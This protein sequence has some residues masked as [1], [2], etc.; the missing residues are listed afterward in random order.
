MSDIDTLTIGEAREA[1][2]RGKEIEKILGSKECSKPSP[3]NESTDHG[4]QI[5]ILDR[6]YVYVG[7]VSIDDNWVLIT[8][9]RNVRRW[10]TTKGL[11]EL[12][13]NGPLKDSI[14]DPVGTVR[15]P[16]RALIGLI[17]CEASKWTK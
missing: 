9:A 6:G 7:N 17:E 11:G 14:I 12:A 15:A 3:S 8:T 4:L 16:L 1:V 5:I 10:G 13:A 2:Q